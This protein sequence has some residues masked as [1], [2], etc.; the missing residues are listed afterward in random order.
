MS[1]YIHF[2]IVIKNKTR[3]TPTYINVMKWRRRLPCRPCQT[4][5]GVLP[6]PN[7]EAASGSQARC[8]RGWCRASVHFRR[9]RENIVVWFLTKFP[10]FSPKMFGSSSSSPHHHAFASHT[11]S[12]SSSP[13]LSLSHNNACL[14][15][16]LHL[17]TIYILNN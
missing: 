1:S 4:A 7:Q 10:L 13:S 14:I 8:C 16:V 3:F 12:P 11:R 17:K 5:C 9:V 6:P 15:H 2:K